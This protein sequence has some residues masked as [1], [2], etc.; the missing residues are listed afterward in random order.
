MKVIQNLQR[1]YGNAIRRHKGDVAAMKNACW[2]VYYHSVS[3]DSEPKH[4]CCPVGKG[5]WCSYQRAL[6]EGKTLPKHDPKIPK[7]LAEHIKPVFERL[8]NDELLGR[9]E[10]GAT[11]NQNESFN[12]IIWRRCPK[13]EYVTLPSVEVAVNM[14]VLSFNHG[15]KGLVSLHES[16]CGPMTKFGSDLF[17]E[18]D[19]D[20]IVRAGRRARDAA[21]KRRQQLRLIELA[22]EERNLQAEGT[23]YSSG[24]F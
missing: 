17:A 13:T 14:A 7:D 12:A 23:T 2:A 24:G 15:M 6:A 21:K 20:R 5:S 4:Q 1:Y 3:T 19:A 8:C 18:C 11:Q 22:R 10:L 16:F 9:C